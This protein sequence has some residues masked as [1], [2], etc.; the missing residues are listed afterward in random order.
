MDDIPDTL[1]AMIDVIGME[2]FLEVSKLYGGSNVYIPVPSKVV[3]G[4][5]NREIAR[6]YNG[7]N[8]DN[9]RLRYGISTQHLKRLLRQEGIII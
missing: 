2:K 5:R 3:M 1:H 9:L 7:K 4:N 6:E 8:I